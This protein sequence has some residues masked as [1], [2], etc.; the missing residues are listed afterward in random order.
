[1]KIITGTLKNQPQEFVDMV[2]NAK[3]GNC[4]IHSFPSSIIF[5]Y[6]AM[7]NPQPAVFVC[8]STE[9]ITTRFGSRDRILRGARYK[10]D[11]LNEK[12]IKV[13][14]TSV[15]CSQLAD[16]EPFPGDVSEYIDN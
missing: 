5:S 15:W 2:T 8:E 14:N 11:K 3:P 10:F 6:D 13:E 7:G 9:P 1:M 16:T 4:Y 12:L